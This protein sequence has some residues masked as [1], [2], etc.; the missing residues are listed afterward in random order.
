MLKQMYIAMGRDHT[1]IVAIF[2]RDSN[3]KRATEGN[4]ETDNAEAMVAREV[5][6]TALLEHI[7]NNAKRVDVLIATSIIQAGVSIDTHFYTSFD[8][9]HCDVLSY[10]EELQ[11]S[12]RLRTHRRVNV[13]KVRF[14]YIEIGR[15]QGRKDANYDTVLYSLGDISDSVRQDFVLLQTAARVKCNQRDSTQR[16]QYLWVRDYHENDIPHTSA[17]IVDALSGVQRTEPYEGRMS[18]DDEAQRLQVD[19]TGEEKK[20]KKTGIR[21]GDRTQLRFDKDLGGKGL[22]HGFIHPFFGEEWAKGKF[23]VSDHCMYLGLNNSD[24]APITRGIGQ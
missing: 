11:L 15:V 21:Y 12:M 14:L 4:D 1:R 3:D 19:L 13:G 6:R 7:N 16:H 24:E 18:E 22:M 8:F 2:G 20:E 10:G 23:K 17:V 9:M 5:L